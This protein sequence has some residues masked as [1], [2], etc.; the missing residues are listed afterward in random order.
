MVEADFGAMYSKND[1]QSSRKTRKWIAEQKRLRERE[2]AEDKTASETTKPVEAVKSMVAKKKPTYKDVDDFFEREDQLA[3]GKAQPMPVSEEKQAEIDIK[4]QLEAEAAIQRE[5][6]AAAEKKRQEEEK[7]R[8]REEDEQFQEEQ[9]R[10]FL[11]LMRLDREKQEQEEAER[12]ARTGELRKPRQ[13]LVSSLSEEWTEKVMGT[14]DARPNAVLARTPEAAELRQKDFQTV[15]R[16][17]EWLNDEIVN[18]TLMHV[19]NWAN[20]RAGVEKPNVQ[21]PKSVVFNSFVGKNL[22][23]GKVPSDRILRKNG[24]RKDNFLDIQNIMIPI[25]RGAHWTLVGVRPTHREVF[26]LD[27]LDYKGDRGLMTKALDMVRSILKDAFVE[28]EWKFSK[29]ESPQQMNSDDCG[30]HTITN[31]MCL[32]LGLKMSTYSSKD[33]PQQRLRIAAVCLNEGF[34]G[35]LTLD[36]I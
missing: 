12:L 36:G 14:L 32:G 22:L 5:Y 29:L 10:K 19:A 28:N 35:D 16:P 26:H 1:Q 2:A 25:C 30:V 17:R 4:K 27:S 6:A 21:T 24:V 9:R 31:G 3:W 18:G 7:R 20:Q 13:P 33:M 8:I 34:T 11:E 15:V 23:A